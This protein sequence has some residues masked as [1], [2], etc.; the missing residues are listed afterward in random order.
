[1]NVNDIMKQAHAE[2]EAENS[3]AAVNQAKIKIRNKGS[4]WNKVFPWKIV[5]V[6]KSE[7]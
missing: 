5:F 4:F 1:M 7:I 2:I 6:K 3:R